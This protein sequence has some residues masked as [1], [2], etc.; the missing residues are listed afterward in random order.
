[1]ELC[2]N[3]W[4]YI[5]IQYNGDQIYAISEINIS[6]KYLILKK[7]HSQFLFNNIQLYVLTRILNESSYG[8]CIVTLLSVSRYV[9]Y[10]NKKSNN[11]KQTKT[12]IE[13]HTHKFIQKINTQDKKIQTDKTQRQH[14]VWDIHIICTIYVILTE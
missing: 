13:K 8:I 6:G 14:I 3:I 12:I 11:N 1:M 2:T 10:V 5:I 9:W 7:R 4:N